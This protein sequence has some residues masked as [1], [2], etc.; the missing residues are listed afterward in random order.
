MYQ[1]ELQKCQD[2]INHLKTHY[3]PHAKNSGKDNITMIV[4]KHTTYVNDKFHDLPYY[5]VRIQRSKRYIKLRWFDEHF[6]DHEV[7]VEIDN[8]N[9]IRTFNRFEGHAERKYNHFRLIDLTR[10][11]LYAM[12]VPA[13]FDD[14]E[15]YNFL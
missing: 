9:S 3:V 10:E 14:E 15:E 8:S 6:S 4:Q 13:I 2:T 12:L 5:V 7:I 11:E 1:A